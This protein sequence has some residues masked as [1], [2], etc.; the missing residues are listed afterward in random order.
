MLRTSIFAVGTLV[1]SIALS[2]SVGAQSISVALDLYYNNPNDVLSGGSWELIAVAAD[3]GLAGL[4]VSLDGVNC[5]MFAAPTG[6]GTSVTTAGF[7]E[8]IGGVN[9]ATQSGTTW[10]LIFGQVPS[11]SPGPQGLFYDVGVPGG[12]TQPGANG[13]P[14]ILGLSGVNVPWGYDDALGDAVDGNPQDGDGAFEGG[15]LLSRGTF[16][17]GDSPAVLAGGSGT[18]FTALGTTANPPQLGTVQAAT[19]TTFVRSNVG[20][21]AGDANLDGIVDGDDFDIWN[22]NR[23]SNQTGYRLGDFNGDKVV[24]VSD[25]NIWN[26]SKTQSLQASTVVPEFSSIRLSLMA[27]ALLLLKRKLIFGCNDR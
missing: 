27:V 10:N 13:T 6:T 11:N 3:R 9:F 14:G 19:A 8:S 18:I 16:G 2:S 17:V 20:F 4:N 23:F 25:F 21:L 5:P 22:A 7:H 24:D 15:V 1:I 26:A 12:A